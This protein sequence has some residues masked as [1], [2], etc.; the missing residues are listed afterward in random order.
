M[1][2]REQVAH[3]LADTCTF[4]GLNESYGVQVTK[5][6]ENGK[7]FWLVTFARARTLD[8]LIRVYS[9]VFIQVKWQGPSGR[10]SEVLRSPAA[11][12]AF[13]TSKFIQP[14]V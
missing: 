10:G 11:A 5:S 2:P 3:D 4:G 7:N 14:Y 6:E 12:K 1:S 13:L 8:G 9:P